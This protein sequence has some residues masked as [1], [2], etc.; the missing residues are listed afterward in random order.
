MACCEATERGLSLWCA[1]QRYVEEA[2]L[3]PG[4]VSSTDIVGVPASTNRRK[5]VTL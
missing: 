2:Y 5:R 1:D 4:V 3:L